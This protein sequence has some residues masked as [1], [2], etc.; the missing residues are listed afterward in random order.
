ME[1]NFYFEDIHAQIISELKKVQGYIGIVVVWFAY[2]LIFRDLYRRVICY[3]VL[4]RTS[5]CLP[6]G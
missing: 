5:I 1:T 3:G 6:E 4:F 2:K